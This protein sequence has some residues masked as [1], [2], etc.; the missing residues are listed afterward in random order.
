MEETLVLVK[1]DGVQ[2]NLIGEV[3]SRIERV[4]LKIVGLKLLQASEKLADQHYQ[5][6][7]EW[8]TSVAE[9]TREAFAKQGIT[10]DETD[11]EIGQRVQGWLKSYLL[12]GPVVAMVVR[13]NEAIDSIRKLIG[14]K[15]PKNATPGTIRGDFST[16]SY[17]LA[18]KEKRAIRNL[19]HA[20][21]STDEAQREI[22]LWFKK[23]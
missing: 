8:Y 17:A 11:L 9:K 4:G 23:A 15:E 19:V 10:L 21:G 2:K 20:S 12:E 14:F 5:L 13:G 22:K 3:I 16:D 7:E 1:P 6:S 18:D